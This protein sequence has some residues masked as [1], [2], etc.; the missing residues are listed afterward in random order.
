MKGEAMQNIDKTETT[1]APRR[2]VMWIGL[3]AVAIL[4]VGGGIWFRTQHAGKPKAKQ[5][6]PKSSM[7]DMSSMSSKPSTANSDATDSTTADAG[8]QVDLGPDDLKK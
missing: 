5:D 2:R 4:A 7:S 8:V 1:S 6:A 3:G